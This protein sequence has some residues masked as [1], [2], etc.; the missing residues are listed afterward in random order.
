M[1]LNL[2]LFFALPLSVLLIICG[3]LC[4]GALAAIWFAVEQNRTGQVQVLRVVI[5]PDTEPEL[6]EKI[7]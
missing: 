1:I 3:A 5:H 7:S 2:L 4:F 6:I